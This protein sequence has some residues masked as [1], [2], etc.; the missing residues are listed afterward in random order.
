[1]N[2]SVPP[3]DPVILKNAH[4]IR[5][6][7]FFFFHCSPRDFLRLQRSLT[8][9]QKTIA[10][11]K[12][13]GEWKNL[14]ICFWNWNFRPCKKKKKPILQYYIIFLALVSIAVRV[15][16]FVFFYERTTRNIRSSCL[17][18]EIPTDLIAVRFLLL[19]E[20]YNNLCFFSTIKG[21]SNIDI[22][23]NDRN[24]RL[25][26]IFVSP[27]FYFIAITSVLKAMWPLVGQ[28]IKH[29]AIQIWILHS[30]SAEML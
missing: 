21:D 23:P 24:M 11:K 8:D 26:G 2:R 22:N 20:I 18:S 28:E 14:S 29:S 17:V 30:D 10:G 27:L 3:I 4:R 1:M 5:R 9:F 19:S 15:F 12:S 16:F 13:T 6:E 25:E 7:F